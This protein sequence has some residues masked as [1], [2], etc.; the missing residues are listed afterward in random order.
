MED[1]GAK[2]KSIAR[3][4]SSKIRTGEWPVGH[5]VESE[6]EIARLWQV[7]RPTAHRA[8]SELQR[9]GLV[10]RQRRRGTVVADTRKKSTHLVALIFDHVAKQFDFPQAELIQGIQEILG[11]AFSLVWC[12]SLDDPKREAQ[13]LERMSRE[14]DGIICLPIADPVNTPLMQSLQSKRCPLVLLDR[15]PDGYDGCAVVSDDRATTREAVQ[16]LGANGHMQIG[17]LGFYKPNV[18]SALARYESYR[19]AMGEL[20]I[21]DPSRNCRWFVRQLEHEPDLFRQSVR[22]S[23]FALQRGADPVTAIYC[24]QDSFANEVSLY[25]QELGIRIPEDLEVVVVNEWPQHLLNQSESMH[26]IVR[27]KRE[28]GVAAAERLLSLSAGE[29][30]D[31][32]VLRIPAEL[33]PSGVVATKLNPRLVGISSA[34]GG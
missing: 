7:S 2:W 18:S 31:Q 3:Q 9:E 12:D 11:E 26:R 6:E 30:F 8:L 15:I 4:L 21:D 1:G 28:I 25:C 10:V 23:I 24:I 16:L 29:T 33:H 20:G 34:N 19:T 22:D 13:F 14:T 5:Q 27:R 32:P 17:F